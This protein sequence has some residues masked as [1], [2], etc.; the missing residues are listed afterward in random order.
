MKSSRRGSRGG[1]FTPIPAATTQEEEEEQEKKLQMKIYINL[2]SKNQVQAGWS[3]VMDRIIES[4]GYDYGH[5]FITP[6]I[7]RQN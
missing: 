2:L 1:G 3:N 4:G 6:T 7:K 5:N